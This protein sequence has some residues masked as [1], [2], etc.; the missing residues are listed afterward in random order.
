[1]AAFVLRL[2]IF[3]HPKTKTF[4]MESFLVI[5]KTLATLPASFSYLCKKAR[6]T[7]FFYLRM[8][9]NHQHLHKGK[10]HTQENHRMGQVL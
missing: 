6:Q 9:K 3:H 7:K 2:M 10:P 1:V 4:C 8:M 5:K